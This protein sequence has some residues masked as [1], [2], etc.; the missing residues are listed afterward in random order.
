MK[1]AAE[2][3]NITLSGQTIVENTSENYVVETEKHCI[4]LDSSKVTSYNNENNRKT[5]SRPRM[6]GIA[7][8]M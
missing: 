5:A 8:V 6:S 1:N 7:Y 2:N 4:Q 3:K